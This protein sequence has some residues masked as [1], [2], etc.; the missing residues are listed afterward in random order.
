MTVFSFFVLEPIFYLLD[1]L[2]QWGQT[3]F[4]HP[5]SEAQGTP[6]WPRL[7]QFVQNSMSIEVFWN[8]ATKV[9][10]HFGKWKDLQTKNITNNNCVPF[11]MLL[12]LCMYVQPSPHALFFANSVGKWW[13]HF[14]LCRHPLLLWSQK[15]KSVENWPNTASC[16]AWLEEKGGTGPGRGGWFVLWWA[17]RTS[18]HDILHRLP[19]QAAAQLQAS[20]DT[21][22]CNCWYIK[23]TV[24]WDGFLS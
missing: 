2:E 23:G 17:G 16:V 7:N 6:T 4:C 22:C 21:S 24:A 10:I 1:K 13:W 9:C 11:Y 12:T 8:L 5:W 3:F 14:S 19:S 20:G 18:C 15:S